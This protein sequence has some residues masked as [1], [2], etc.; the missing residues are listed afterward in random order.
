MVSCS[1]THLHY[2]G[3][4][5][6]EW[7]TGNDRTCGAFPDVTSGDSCTRRI[8]WLWREICV[9]LSS[10][11]LMKI[12]NLPL[13]KGAV[14]SVTSHAPKVNPNNPSGATGITTP[15]KCPSSFLSTETQRGRSFPAG[16]WATHATVTF[17]TR[18]DTVL[19]WQNKSLVDSRL[20]VVP[21]QGMIKRGGG[22]VQYGFQT[23]T[24]VVKG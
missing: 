12:P 16:L 2:D 11:C 1:I 19:T 3:G 22:T 5:P 8:L 24:N 7:G 20:V 9:C 4:A 18:C 14:T 10:F 23:L 15:F 21:Y 6:T 17:P 13:M